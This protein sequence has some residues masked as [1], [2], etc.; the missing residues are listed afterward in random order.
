M[1]TDNKSSANVDAVRYSKKLVEK[2]SPSDIQN[3]IKRLNSFL[4]EDILIEGKEIQLANN[5]ETIL[6]KLDS[7]IETQAP[8]EIKDEMRRVFIEK[9]NGN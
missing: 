3:Y 1:K 5:P 2:Y 7:I 8:V 6:R 9:L 4:P